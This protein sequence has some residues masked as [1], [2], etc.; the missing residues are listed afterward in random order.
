M[1]TFCINFSYVGI[2]WLKRCSLTG[3]LDTAIY[4]YM[5][6]LQ[7]LRYSESM[8]PIFSL[9]RKCYST[10]AAQ[11]PAPTHL[12]TQTKVVVCGG[13]VIGTSVAY[14]LA[15]RGWTDVIIL[16]QGA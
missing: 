2:R 6:N 9:S 3:P 14:H 13:G 16:E 7:K 10:A 15:E 8:F 4:V 5:Y 12:P 1:P 11:K